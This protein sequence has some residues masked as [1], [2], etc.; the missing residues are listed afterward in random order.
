[1][2]C[3]CSGLTCV[4]ILYALLTSKMHP[5]KARYLNK[6]DTE[7]G[8]TFTQTQCE[9][10]L[11]FAHRAFLA[12][13]NQQLQNRHQMVLHTSITPQN[14]FHGTLLLVGD[15]ETLRVSYYTFFGPAQDY[16]PFGGRIV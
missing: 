12:T 2:S 1:M 13:A 4:S 8:V 14:Q 6:W 7:L 15:V 10:I 3:K 5:Q 11:L 16:K 9:N